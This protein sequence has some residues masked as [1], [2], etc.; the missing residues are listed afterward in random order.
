MESTAIQLKRAKDKERTQFRL[1]ICFIYLLNVMEMITYK[2][3]C[4]SV[5]KKFH[6]SELKENV[7]AYKV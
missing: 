1:F 5:E 7:V 6:I 4:T 2:D 3:V